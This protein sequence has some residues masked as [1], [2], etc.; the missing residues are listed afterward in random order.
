MEFQSNINSTNC[1]YELHIYRTVAIL[2]TTPH[3]ATSALIGCKRT[4]YEVKINE[5]PHFLIRIPEQK[6]R[7]VQS[8]KKRVF[9]P[10]KG[11]SFVGGFPHF[12]HSKSWST[13]AHP[14]PASLSK[15]SL[16]FSFLA[17]FDAI[18]I[19]DS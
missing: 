19:E 10:V 11:Q 12:S 7:Q 15:F 5:W 2:A 6:E 3:I 17:C 13:Q 14:V 8:F 4:S 9:L 1:L 16:F 18:C